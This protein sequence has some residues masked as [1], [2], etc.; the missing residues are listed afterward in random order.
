LT[1]CP[2]VFS[3]C[4]LNSISASRSFA[5]AC[6]TA[7]DC[8]RHKTQKSEVVDDPIDRNELVHVPAVAMPVAAEEV[9]DALGFDLTLGLLDFLI[10]AVE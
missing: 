5:R 8:R 2:G 7:G 4:R 6:S 10:C 9:V 3:R 1:I